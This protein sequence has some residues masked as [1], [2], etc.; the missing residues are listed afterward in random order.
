M[1]TQM[2]VNISDT[3]AIIAVMI[4]AWSLFQNHRFNK[5]QT[6]FEAKHAE[7]SNLLIE[8]EAGEAEAQKKADISANFVKIGEHYRL[9]VFNRGKCSA[10]NVRLEVLDDAGLLQKKYYRQEISRPNSGAAKPY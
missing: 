10:S 2:Q 9:K 6:E 7:L 8:K 3:L 4:S 5:R 1:I